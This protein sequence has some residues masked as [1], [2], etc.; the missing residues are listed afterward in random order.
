[1]ITK[2]PTASAPL[3]NIRRTKEKARI[4]SSGPLF[5][6]LGAVAYRLNPF[7]TTVSVTVAVCVLPPP[8]PVIVMV[9]VPTVARVPTLTVIVD[10]PEPG[11]AMGFGLNVTVCWFPSPEADKVTAESKP[12]SAAVVI[13]EVPD[14]PLTT[15][16]AVGD[17]L[18]LKSAP[19][20][21]VT[22]RAT[23][24]FCVMPPPVP[25]TVIV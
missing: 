16:I 11:A 22:V 15:E 23:V 19:A 18:M 13:V 14:W 6:Q 17:A 5:A 9:W 7:L 24:V 1:M 21:A 10:D 12:L 20:A 2:S 25:V 4:I 3:S 8:V